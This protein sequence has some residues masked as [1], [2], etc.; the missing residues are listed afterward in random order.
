M[1]IHGPTESRNEWTDETFIEMRFWDCQIKGKGIKDVEL[2]RI[3]VKFA[4]CN[5][6][7]CNFH[8]WKE[9]KTKNKSA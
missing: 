2:D 6:R 7:G 9:I 1:L 8:K 5:T 3:K 4:R